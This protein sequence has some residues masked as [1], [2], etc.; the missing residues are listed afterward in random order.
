[1]LPLKLILPA[2]YLGWMLL[3]YL[4]G[5]SKTHPLIENMMAFF[6]VISPL[7]LIDSGYDIFIFG[8]IHP[9]QVTCCS[10]ATDVSA[11]ALAGP[12]LGPFGQTLVLI[13]L[14]VIGGVLAAS[15][16]MAV[17][18]QRAYFIALALSLPFAGV[19]FLNTMEV[20]CPWLLHLPFHRCP[21]CLIQN[22]PPAVLFTILMWF[23]IAAPWLAF[24]TG[25]MGHETAETEQNE[26]KL[27][28]TLLKLAGFA[29]L[30]ALIIIAVCI[31]VSMS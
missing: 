30:M 17:K 7:V 6:I 4:D 29:V 27:R 8:E 20:L 2:L 11:S 9:V 25:K 1:V 13:S 26:T 18:S 23:G 3:Y 22:Y 16:L 28:G 10:S 5:K 21:F 31:L 19:Y 15:L 24:M 14:Y 12:L